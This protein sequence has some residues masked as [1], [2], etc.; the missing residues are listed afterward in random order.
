ME[1]E[2]DVVRLW[3]EDEKIFVE[4]SDRKQY[5]QSLLW[6]PRLINATDKERE[7]FNCSYSGIHFPDIDEDISFE[8]FLR[9]NPEPVGISRVFLSHPELNASAIARRLNMPQ[10]LLAAYIRGIKIPSK[11]REA[12]IINEIKTVGK[13]LEF[14]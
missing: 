12:E 10:S 7:N 6:Y 2:L 1:K 4:T 9:N 5:F 11:K 3:F 14:V 8:S 13:E